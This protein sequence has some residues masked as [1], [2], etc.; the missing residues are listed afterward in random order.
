MKKTVRKIVAALAIFVLLLS[1]AACGN[2]SFKCDLCNDEKTGKSHKTK[3]LGEEVEICD[4]CYED[5]QGLM[6]N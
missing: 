3:V 6:G 4:D 1:L 5:I 2:K